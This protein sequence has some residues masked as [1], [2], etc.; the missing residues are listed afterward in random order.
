MKAVIFRAWDTDAGWP[1]RDPWLSQI[2]WGNIQNCQSMREWAQ[3]RD[4]A[5]LIGESWPPLS[6]VNDEARLSALPHYREV[7]LIPKYSFNFFYAI[8]N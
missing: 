7:S 2:L 4:D 6:I 5:E 8:G 1:L 3:W